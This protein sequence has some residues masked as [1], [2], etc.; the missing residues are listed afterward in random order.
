MSSH[1][2]SSTAAVSGSPTLIRLATPGA[3]D[4]RAIGVMTLLCLVWSLQQISLKAVADQ[5]SPMLMIALRSLIAL[6]LLA[7]LM[8]RRGEGLSRGR[9]KPG[10]VVGALFAV[11][12]LLVSEALRLTHASHVVVFLY[13]APIFAALGLHI[14]LPAERLGIVQW[15]G[16]A[17]AFGG[18]AMTFLG[19]EGM[20]GGTDA[21]VLLGDALALTAGA[22]WGATTVAIRCSTLASA[23]ATETLF[24]QLL[25]AFVLLLPAAWPTGQRHFE[26]SAL[27]WAHLGFQ[28]LIVS[29]ASFLT[30]CWLLR[31]YLASQLGVFSFLTPLFGVV[32]GVWLLGESLEPQ[33]IAGSGFVLAGIGMVSG[34]AGL[35]RS[36]VAL[37]RLAQAGG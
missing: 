27:V 3:L 2:A 31:R 25:G 15:G 37:R 32:L 24:Y 5:A 10:A 34:H 26:P 14:R 11:E 23:P 21:R 16:I 4:P 13:T 30:W 28:S 12:Y 6:L 7:T 33:F 8:Y 17:L 35:S 1:T 36:L 9:W 19:G 20:S 29:F 22:A 18:I